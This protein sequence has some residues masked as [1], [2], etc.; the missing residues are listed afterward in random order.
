MIAEDSYFLNNVFSA[1]IVAFGVTSRVCLL[2]EEWHIEA[3]EREKVLGLQGQPA[4]SSGDI[5]G[6][7]A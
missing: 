4:I 1:V 5:K 7:L 6:S 2:M 3:K